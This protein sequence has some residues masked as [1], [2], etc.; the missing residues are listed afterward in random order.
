MT[1]YYED[2]TVGQRIIGVFLGPILGLAYVI[3]MPFLAI[4]T[5]TILVGR[6]GVNVLLGLLRSLASFGWRP[7]EAY[8]SGKKKRERKNK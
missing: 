1:T 7:S 4:G 8:L 6:K 2:S 3:C 5:I